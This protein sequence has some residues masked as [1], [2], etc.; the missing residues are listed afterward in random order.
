MGLELLVEELGQTLL[1]LLAGA[2]AIGVLAA[3]LSVATSF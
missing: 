3:V 1:A 2:A